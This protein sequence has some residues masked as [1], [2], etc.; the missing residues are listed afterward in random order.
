MGEFQGGTVL[1]PH[2]RL[3]YYEMQEEENRQHARSQTGGNNVVNV[4][5][6]VTNSPIQQGTS[7]SSQTL[8]SAPMERE[9][10]SSPQQGNCAVVL[11][12]LPVEF[13]AVAKHVTDIRRI[14]HPH[15]TLYE[16]GTFLASSRSWRVGIVETGPGNPSAAVEAERAISYFQPQVVLFVG[17]AGGIKDVKLGDVVA[18]TKVYG[19]E[20]GKTGIA[21]QPRPEVFRSTHRMVQHARAEARGTAWLRRISG[22]A[23]TSHPQAFVKPIAAGEQVIAET[24]SE[25]YQ[26]L[27]THYG[28][29]IAVEMEGRGFLQAAHANQQVDALLIRGI[30]DLIDG[31]SH[32]DASGSQ[33]TA[34]NHASAF[35]FEVLANLSLG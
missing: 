24:Q 10:G 31:K 16:H 3:L 34:A 1:L 20:A 26:F 6:S 14:A 11:T 4:Y 15:G 22:E 13:M 32:A 8:N 9:K 21:F 28:D 7:N 30:S 35:A 27:R 18:A 19:Y 23:P 5:G 33:E 2:G 17:I 29:A 25:V 12:A